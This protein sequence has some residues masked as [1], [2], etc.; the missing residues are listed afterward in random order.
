MNYPFS[1]T[2]CYAFLDI[3][4]D[5]LASL[6][7]ELITFGKE[8]GLRGL[9]LLSTEGVNGT[10]CG[11]P[12]AIGEWKDLLTTLFG[13]IIFKDSHAEKQVFRRFSVKIKPEIV[14]IKDPDLHP[15]GPHKHL[16]PAEWQKLIDEGDVLL[17]DTR[18]DY[19]VAIGSFK[20]AI[21]PKIE[22]FSD[23]PTFVQKANL[24]KDKKILMYCTGGIRCEKAL[25]AMEK[26]GYDNVYQL[27]GGILAYLQQFPEKSFKGE[28]FVFDHRVSVDQQ[29]L[30]SQKYGLCP[31]CGDPADQLVTC[32]CG[33][34]KKVCSEC[35]TDLTQR[36]CS[37][38]CRNVLRSKQK[39]VSESV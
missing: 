15:K 22:A 19:E 10:I 33:T 17:L 11:V 29:L 14:V 38:H 16:S 34:S 5:R 23:F 4:K 32:Y 3:S 2:A 13:P 8:R 12:Q 37:K 26:Q 7:K 31:H 21:D 30:P 36:T 9:F 1:I 20:D 6:K 18:N 25:L 27:E 35:F 24:P 39:L 28:C